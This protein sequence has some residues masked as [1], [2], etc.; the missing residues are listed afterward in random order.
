MVATKIHDSI[1]DIQ[2]LTNVYLDVPYM[3]GAVYILNTGFV[4]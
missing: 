1:D 2:F 3:Q 4:Y